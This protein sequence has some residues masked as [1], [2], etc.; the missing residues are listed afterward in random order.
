VIPEDALFAVLDT[1][2]KE[3]KKWK[4]EQQKQV[5]ITTFSNAE[6]FPDYKLNYT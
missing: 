4:E 5:R 6:R 2:H 3:L 1:Q